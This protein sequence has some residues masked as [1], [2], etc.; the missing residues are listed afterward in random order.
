MSRYDLSQPI[1]LAR[2]QFR[3]RVQHLPTLRM[4]GATLINYSTLSKF[5]RGQPLEVHKECIRDKSVS[6]FTLCRMLWPEC[7]VIDAVKHSMTLVFFLGNLE[8][9]RKR[10]PPLKSGGFW[11][12]FYCL[13]AGKKSFWSWF[14]W[15]CSS[16]S[17]W[18][19]CGVDFTIVMELVISTY[20][21]LYSI[22]I[23]SKQLLQ[24]KV[25]WGN[26]CRNA[27]HLHELI[28]F[29]PISYIFSPPAMSP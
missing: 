21:A 28:I 7:V 11:S 16:V 24:C 20:I 2:W 23:V 27:K 13:S 8:L 4:S 15:Y 3:V 14:Q 26:A 19:S 17:L 6:E 25:F 12:M 9:H 29:T 22:Q 5:I 1:L 10:P 18:W